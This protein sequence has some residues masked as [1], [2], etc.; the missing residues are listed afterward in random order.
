MIIHLWD[1]ADIDSLKQF[2]DYVNSMWISFSNQLLDVMDKNVAHKLTRS[3]H[4]NPW[5]ETNIRRLTKNRAH[6]KDKSIKRQKDQ[7][8]Y[9]SLKVKYQDNTRKAHNNYMQDIISP[10]AK[11]EP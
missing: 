3:R 4:T 7:Q 5:I 1:R 11:K 10:E 9:R 8:R 6:Q 2:V